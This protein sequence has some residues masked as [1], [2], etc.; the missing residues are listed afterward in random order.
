ML[1]AQNAV[2]QRG[3][4]ECCICLETFD[5]ASLPAQISSCQHQF[6]VCRLCHIN[7]L[8]SQTY[9][10]AGGIKCST[11][12]CIHRYCNSSLLILLGTQKGN[13][14]RTRIEEATFLAHPLAMLCT[15]PGCGG[16]IW[17]PTPMSSTTSS[18]SIAVSPSV[19]CPTCAAVICPIC[20]C[21]GHDEMTC[22][23]YAREKSS[24]ELGVSSQELINA[25]TKRCPECH[26]RVMK[27]GGCAHMKCVRCHHDWCFGC[28]KPRMSHM[29]LATHAHCDQR[30]RDFEARAEVMM[31]Q[32]LSAQLAA[33]RAAAEAAKRQARMALA[34]A[35]AI[36]AAASA[37]TRVHSASNDDDDDDVVV[38]A[39][40]FDND[41]ETEP[42]AINASSDNITLT[43]PLT[44]STSSMSFSTRT[45]SMNMLAAAAAAAATM[46]A[47]A[48]SPV[49]AV[50][51][52]GV[53]RNTMR[54]LLAVSF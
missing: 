15:R 26:Y 54:R 24:N 30:S 23:Q 29:D 49:I 16:Q 18:T 17:K 3:F 51:A 14:L 50:V 45:Q 8:K 52:P 48:N 28:M 53:V 38:R 22:E 42:I 31:Q 41:E 10:L 20:L 4:R 34:A 11:Q 36:A 19:V 33:Q 12:G 37:S 27:N 39:D 47:N 40:F 13:E 2:R 25:M 21:E 44:A 7:Y 5:C 43:T 32:Y 46:R 35:A 1:P 6:N 9:N